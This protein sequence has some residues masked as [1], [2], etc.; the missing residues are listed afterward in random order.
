MKNITFISDTHG[1]HDEITKDLLGGDFLIHSGDIS[2]QGTYWE[3]YYFC[4]WFSKI[5][6]YKHKIFV[7]GNHDW[8]FQREP[9]RAK[10]ILR[11]FKNITYL[12]DELVELD[13]VKI[14][15]SPWQPEFHGWAFNLPKNGGELQS[16]WDMIPNN[17][18]IL[19]THGPCFGHLDKVIGR[20]DNLGCELLVKKVEEVKPKIHCCGH[21]HTGR[22][23]K[24][25]ENT[26]YINSSVLN[27]QYNYHFQPIQ[28]QF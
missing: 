28:L 12:Q 20:N 17:I 2:P 19:V 16:K 15:G 24:Q 6:N 1:K 13:G 25:T 9:E 27:E 18:D 7:A 21:I 5:P 10:E 22:G 3:V 8:L 4:K 26:L 14:Y 23:I 11:L